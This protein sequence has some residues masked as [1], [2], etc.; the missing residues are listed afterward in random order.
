MQLRKAMGLVMQEPTLFNY[1]IKENI[2][3]GNLEASNAEIL[4]A[5]TVSN[6]LEFIRK[7]ELAELF[8]DSA[9]SLLNAMTS[10][11]YRSKMEERLGEEAYAE[12]IKTLTDLAAKDEATGK[13]KAINDLVDNRTEKQMG[14]ELLHSGF[15]VSAGNKGNKLSG[16]QK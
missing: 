9:E 13:F 10:Q 3:Y 7:D 12:A 5:C 4:Q 11:K 16:G 1:S 8:E 15:E 2:L 6:A 14:T